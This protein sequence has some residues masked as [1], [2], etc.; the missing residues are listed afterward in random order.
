MTNTQKYCVDC[1]WSRLSSILR[2]CM[3]CHP[4]VV[5]TVKGSD[6]RELTCTI[7]RFWTKCGPDG[8]LFEGR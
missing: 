5:N 7:A 3:C 1:K 6:K 2:V 8:K 4:V